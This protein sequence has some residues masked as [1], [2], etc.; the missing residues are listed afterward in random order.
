VLRGPLSSY[1]L[2]GPPYQWPTLPVARHAKRG[3]VW[4]KPALHSFQ[5]SSRAGVAT[6]DQD[7]ITPCHAHYP[8]P[9]PLPPYP[10]PCPPRTPS[11]GPRHRPEAHMCVTVPHVAVDRWDVRPSPIARLRPKSPIWAR[12]GSGGGGQ[13]S[14]AGA[15]EQGRHTLRT[16]MPTGV[17][18]RFGPV[19]RVELP[20]ALP[21]PRPRH[22]VITVEHRE[23]YR[24]KK[25]PTRYHSSGHST[26]HLR[27]IPHLRAPAAVDSPPHA[28]SY[29]PFAAYP[30]P[31][32]AHTHAHAQHTCAHA[33]AQHTRTRERA[34]HAH[35]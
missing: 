3:L 16:G 10:L 31:S 26:S 11:P 1:P 23:R 19:I 9:C 18:L 29:V 22:I 28:L 4:V 5:G 32:S 34:T 35:T 20:R 33:S 15:S 24:G 27:P 25:T 7:L 14:G 2:P 30:P 17:L 13:G 8:L 6:E 12:R 21:P